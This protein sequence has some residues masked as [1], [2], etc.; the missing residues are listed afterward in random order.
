MQGLMSFAFADTWNSELIERLCW[1][2]RVTIVIREAILRLELVSDWINLINSISSSNTSCGA[3]LL[4][5]SIQL[6]SY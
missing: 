2:G 1:E 5:S 4:L 6:G 3:L